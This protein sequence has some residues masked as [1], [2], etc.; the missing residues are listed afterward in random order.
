MGSQDALY[1]LYRMHAVAKNAKPQEAEHWLLRAA[2]SGH[3]AAMY[4][5][6]LRYR[7]TLPDQN[8]IDGNEWLAKAAQA[9]HWQAIKA[10]RKKKLPESGD[11]D[12]DE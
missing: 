5:L 3:P 4:H 7:P 1:E 9:G 6:A 10:I 8:R 12:D 2:Q 11:S